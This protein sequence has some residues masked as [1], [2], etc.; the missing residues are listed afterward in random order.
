MET[1]K[2]LN[3]NTGPS[4]GFRAERSLKMATILINIST[5]L[6]GGVEDATLKTRQLLSSLGSAFAQ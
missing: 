3:R 6:L 5:T 4:R 2:Y 1:K